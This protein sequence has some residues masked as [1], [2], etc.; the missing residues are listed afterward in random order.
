[1]TFSLIVIML[2]TNSSLYLLSHHRGKKEKERVQLM[3]QVA[4]KQVPE[5]KQVFTFNENF[6]Y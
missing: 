2:Q 4:S 6:E 5:C 1:M 3:I